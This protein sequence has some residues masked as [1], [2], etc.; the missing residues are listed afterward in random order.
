MQIFKRRMIFRDVGRCGEYVYSRRLY[1][2]TILQLFRCRMECFTIDQIWKFMLMFIYRRLLL[3]VAVRNIEEV[4]LCWQKIAFLLFF[5]WCLMWQIVRNLLE[6]DV[7]VYQFG[8]VF[9]L[10][11]FKQAKHK[12]LLNVFPLWL[13]TDNNLMTRPAGLQSTLTMWTFF[14][15]LICRII[16]IFKGSRSFFDW[17]KSTLVHIFELLVF[18]RPEKLRKLFCRQIILV[19]LSVTAAFT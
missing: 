4:Y 10:F 3:L 8:H 7:E 15:L 11:R 16:L 14:L 2:L 9:S 12:L 18:Y 19:S 1:F 13:I 5:L 6:T 17:R